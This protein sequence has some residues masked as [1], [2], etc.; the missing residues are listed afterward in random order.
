VA[1]PDPA[2][3][4]EFESDFE[5]VSAYGYHTWKLFD[6][7]WLTG[8]LTYDIETY[9]INF[10][11]S[12]I[13]PGEDTRDKLSP[14][15]SLIWSPAPLFTLRMA[16][17]QALGGVSYDETVRLEPT[18]LAGFSQSFRSVI[19]ESFVGSVESPEYEAAYLAMDFQFQTR[20]YVSLQGQVLNSEI[21]RTVGIFD[22]QFAGVPTPGS[23]RELIDYREVTAKAV[24]NQILAN[25]W[26]IEAK[27]QF[28][29]S[30][31]ERSLP[32]LGTPL[33]PAPSSDV[34]ADLH[35]VRLGLLYRHPSGVFGR[36]ETWWLS[37]HNYNYSPSLP[38]DDVF[39]ANIYVGYRFPRER[40]D[41]TIGVLNLADE[42]YRLNPLTPYVDLPRER[43]FYARL[44]LNL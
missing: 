3:A 40:G 7:I 20:T 37:Q 25:D 28:T 24:L 8:G 18:H 15:A 9:P 1:F 16:Y 17:V 42:D 14:K 26:F 29:H 33:S 30:D 23:T 10:R 44:R 39:Q 5:R 19:S 2:A 12:P 4:T 34:Q 38:G 41:I 36:V 21:D 32:L 31:L 22:Y 11:N 27:Y 13:T 35:E 43:L 6:K